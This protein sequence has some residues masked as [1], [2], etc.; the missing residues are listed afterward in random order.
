MSFEIG[1][2]IFPSKWLRP[3]YKYSIL[4]GVE[5]LLGKSIE[6]MRSFNLRLRF[7]KKGIVVREEGMV[8]ER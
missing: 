6:P 3:R 2:M 7:D 1:S 8:P 4:D 5:E